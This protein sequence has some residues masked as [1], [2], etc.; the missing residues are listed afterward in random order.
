LNL[1]DA[2]IWENALISVI[3]KEIGPSAVEVVKNRL[4]EKYGTTIR[5]SFQKWEIVEDI[6]KENFGDGYIRINSK[7]IT[8]IASTH[9]KYG[10]NMFVPQN[11]QNEIIKLIGDPEVGAML[12]QVLNDSKIIKN[13]ISSAKVSQTTAYRK[14]EKMKQLG[15]L[16]EN[17]FVISSIN[18]KIVKY[19]S[20]FES[21]S[22]IHEHG[23]SNIKYGPKKK[24]EDKIITK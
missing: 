2:E 13:I 5:Q 17:G 8:K 11:K 12:D 9:S 23:K 19:T 10:H 15:L 4:L 16:V 1:K 21:F 18:K 22:I 6:L 14:I 3:K 7:L 20:P 24:L